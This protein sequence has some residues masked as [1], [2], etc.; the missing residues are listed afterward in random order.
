MLSL[1]PL[2]FL[3]PWLL[4]GLVALPVI[5]WL[6]RATPP[7]PQQVSF[8]GVRL[9][10][11]LEDPERTPE[12]TPWWLL[13]LRILA[14]AIAILALAD[15]VLN[16]RERGVSADA[17]LLIVMDGGWASAPDWPARQ[18]RVI[19]ALE[20]ADRDGRSVYLEVI[21]QPR[22]ADSFTA[23]PA[24]DWVGYIENLTPAAWSPGRSAFAEEL[25][26]IDESVE[27]L[28]LH[29]GLTDGSTFAE[30]LLA[31]GTVSS[32]GPRQTARAITAP[33]FENGEVFAEVLRSDSGLERRQVIA[34]GPDPNGIQRALG[35]GEAVFEAED[36]R[37]EVRFDLPTELVNRITRLSI[38]GAPSAG[39]V[40]LADDALRRRTVALVAG[41]VSE[42]QI[43]L[44][45]PLHYLRTALEPTAD[46][47]E[48]PLSDVLP[49]APDAIVLADVGTLAR[50]EQDAL[51]T[52]VEGGGLLI[53]FAGPRLASSGT[54]QI[55]RDP[56]LPVRLR[57]GGRSVGGAMS[58]GA[59]KRLRPFA[60]DG[61]FAGLVPPSEVEITSQV[62]AQPD[63]ELANLTLA[64]LEDGTPLVTA[65]SV[66]EGRV[67]LFHVTAGARWSTLPLSGLFVQMLDRLTQSTRPATDMT[68][69]LAGAVWTP[70]RLLDGFGQLQEASLQAG[71][72]GEELATA[73]TGP[74]ARPGLYRAGDRS[75]ALNL[76]AQDDALV[77]LDLPEGVTQLGLDTVEDVF[78]KPLLLTIA[79]ALLLLDALAT[80]A[81]NG[82]LFLS[83]AVAPL[84]AV[85]LLP[86][87]AEAQEVVEGSPVFATSE[88]VIAHILTGDPR[89]DEKARA[90]MQGLALMLNQ[91]TAVEPRVASV[92]LESDELAF[93]PL[94]YW[95][96][97]EGQ[98]TPT[99]EA[100][101]KL[102][103][104][105]R[106]G[107]MLLFDT[108]DANIA[109]VGTSTPNRRTLQRL[110]E[111]LD[112]PPLEPIPEDHVLTRT[113]YLLQAFPGRFING[114]TWVEAAPDPGEYEEGSPFRQLNDGVTPVLIGSN[115]WAAAWAVDD[116]GAPLFQVGRGATGNR[117]REIAYRFGVNVVMYVL[118][119][120]YKSDQVHVPA[121]LERLGQ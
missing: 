114:N 41:D 25:T 93:Y 9:L 76:F 80:L 18:A 67:V 30:D 16:P 47:Y 70:E 105:I 54:G 110:A 88:T 27:V 48:L 28:W 44:L 99:D 24:R 91:R 43:R 23:R 85:M 20:A 6:L 34:F 64:A 87:F 21:A 118:T 42:E 107:G 101:A 120:N 98:P 97:V 121:L 113:F 2:A 65:R 82:R 112:L 106:N 95:P 81:L 63:P 40:A 59:P 7:A 38:E 52:W 49:A 57:A 5:W 56:L 13:L 36:T 33:R 61:P 35:T 14:L 19:S 94:L 89:T 1:G 32:I 17:P 96:V 55:E 29:D 60:E 15:P 90:G 10:L 116:L 77:A 103:R 119:G 4:L 75:F 104:F 66:G 39:A 102:N 79:L 100:Y 51:Q 37:A 11:G 26:A 53:R 50:A 109:A 92:D 71:I 78:Y 45:D 68:S 74:D 69:D 72:P 3:T 46:L 62:M 84:L 8:P 83:R 108:A 86:A 22:A 31:L 58:W 117:Q 115:D 12:R 73:L 111:P